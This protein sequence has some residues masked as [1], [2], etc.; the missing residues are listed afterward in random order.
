MSRKLVRDVVLPSIA[1]DAIVSG[2]QNVAESVPIVISD[3]SVDNNY[4]REVLETPVDNCRPVLT[5]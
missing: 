4:I 1:V 3:D 2:R 5:T